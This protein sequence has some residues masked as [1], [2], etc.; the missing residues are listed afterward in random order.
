V[1]EPDMPYGWMDARV[2]YSGYCGANN[3]DRHGTVVD[4]FENRA[5]VRWD[6]GSTTWD[7]KCDLSGVDQ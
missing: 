3:I 2:R 5:K 4:E 1:T 7:L 6:D